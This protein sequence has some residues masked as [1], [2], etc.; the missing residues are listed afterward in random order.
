MTT[1]SSKTSTDWKVE[2]YFIVKKS[3]VTKF[4]F[5]ADNNVHNQLS[6]FDL[7]WEKKQQQV[8]IFALKDIESV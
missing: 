4:R 3:N 2:I 6:P 5:S 8:K 7:R 1:R